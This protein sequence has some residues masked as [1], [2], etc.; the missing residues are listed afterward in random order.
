MLQ[1]IS[2]KHRLHKYVSRETFH[3]RPK[4]LVQLF[5]GK[6]LHPYQLAVIMVEQQGTQISLPERVNLV[7]SLKNRIAPPFLSSWRGPIS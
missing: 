4:K 6:Q 7:K 3:F 5:P 2:K 1:E